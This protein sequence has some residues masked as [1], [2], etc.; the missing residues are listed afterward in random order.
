MD[1]I[2]N[3]SDLPLK[4]FHI[5]TLLFNEIKICLYHRYG[6]TLGKNKYTSKRFAIICELIDHK[7]CY[8]HN[9]FRVLRM[10]EIRKHFLWFLLLSFYSFF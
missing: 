1:Q 10:E 2:F 4:K 7:F 8:W 9:F 6:Q 3:S 5:F